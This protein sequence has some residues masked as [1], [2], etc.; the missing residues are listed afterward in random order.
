MKVAANTTTATN[1]S[2][3]A[4]FHDEFMPSL[5]GRRGAGSGG[6]PGPAAA[7]NAFPS[8]LGKRRN[9]SFTSP[10]PGYFS[11]FF[12]GSG[13]PSA[14]IGPTATTTSLPGS[15]YFF[16]TACTSAGVT[17]ATPLR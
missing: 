15:R 4:T 14:S 3:M 11:P 5:R 17:A 10:T 8:P 7:F 2:G 9:D 12:A 13:L 1:P 16:A 6:T